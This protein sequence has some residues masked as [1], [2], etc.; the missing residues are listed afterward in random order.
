M[1][2]E[3]GNLATLR[4]ELGAFAGALE[5]EAEALAA[6]GQAG[7]ADAVEAKTRRAE[8]VAGQWRVTGAWLRGQE[9]PGGSLP[10]ALCAEWD[11]ILAL[12]ARVKS[13]NERNA[14]LIEAQMHRTR[15]ALDVLQAAARPVNLYGSDG[16]LQDGAGPGHSLDKA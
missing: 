6:P 2:A 7:L 12:A 14:R 8:A 15:A 4:A 5:H 13:L 3:S 16:Y 1:T 11:E 10:P 9:A